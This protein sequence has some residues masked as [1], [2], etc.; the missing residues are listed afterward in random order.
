MSLFL[1]FLSAIGIEEDRRPAPRSI[2]HRTWG[3]AGYVYQP[4]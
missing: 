4:D 2:G 1:H 3:R